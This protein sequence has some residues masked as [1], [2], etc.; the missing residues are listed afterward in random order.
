MTPGSYKIIT[1]THY[2]LRY[3]VKIYNIHS[4]INARITTGITLSWCDHIDRLCS[5]LIIMLSDLYSPDT[6]KYITLL[7][8]LQI[9]PDITITMPYYIFGIYRKRNMRMHAA[10]SVDCLPYELLG[11]I[12]CGQ[13][14]ASLLW[15][16]LTVRNSQPAHTWINGVCSPMTRTEHSHLHVCWVNTV[17]NWPPHRHTHTP[18]RV[19]LEDGQQPSTPLTEYLFPHHSNGLMHSPVDGTNGER[20]RAD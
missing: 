20:L 16:A 18:L 10:G 2:I 3:D 17:L 12:M 1:H 6:M 19:C 8:I 7:K 14:S 11:K 15:Q 4:R 9:N 13:I 5:L